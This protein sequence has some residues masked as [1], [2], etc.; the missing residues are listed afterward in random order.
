MRIIIDFR[1]N[2]ILFSDYSEVD[3]ESGWVGATRGCRTQ[4]AIFSHAPYMITI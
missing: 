4:L 3:L 1:P 2:A